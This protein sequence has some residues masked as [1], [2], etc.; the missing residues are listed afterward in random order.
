MNNN[1]NGMLSWII[2][3]AVS[4]FGL[5][6]SFYVFAFLLPFVLVIIGVLFLANLLRY[7]YLKNKVMNAA[8]DILN[9]INAQ[10]T[11]SKK[12]H[13]KVIDVDYEVVDNDYSKKY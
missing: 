8:S 4:A 5:V 9:D 7:W 6:L 2:W 12:T 11:D 13:G 3:V 1:F 10:K